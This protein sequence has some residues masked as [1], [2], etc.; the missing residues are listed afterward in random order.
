MLA[1]ALDELERLGIG[2]NRIVALASFTTEDV[3][4]DVLAARAAVQGGPPLEVSIERWR[5]GDEIDELLGIPSEDRP[6]ID[7]PPAP[8]V[9]GTRSIAHGVDRRR[10]HR[11][12]SSHREF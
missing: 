10:H 3:T 1:P 9:A 2:R 7:V 12:P 11:L 6:G 5:R 4:A 8:G